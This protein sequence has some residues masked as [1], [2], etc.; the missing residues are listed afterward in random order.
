LEVLSFRLIVVTH[1]GTVIIL[2]AGQGTRMKSALPKVLHE[3]CGK[4]MIGWVIDQ[5]MSLD[6][7]KIVVV[8]GHGGEAVREVAMKSAG[9]DRIECVVQE[10]QNGTGHA[11]QVAAS[12]IDAGDGT[13]VV[14]YGDMPVLSP[15]SL[16]ELLEARAA[17]GEDGMA[18][19][20]ASPDDPTGLGRIERDEIGR[21]AGIVEHKDANEEQR[22]IGEVNLGVYA[23]HGAGLI[24]CL[25]KLSNDNAQKEYYLTDVP[26]MFVGNG[27]MVATVELDDAEEAIGVNN[28]MQLAE[29][30]W[31]LQVRILEEHLANGVRIEDPASTYVDAD[32][33][34]G[35]GTRILPCTV[36]RAGVVIGEDCEVGPFS[37]LR[38]GTELKDRAE[39]G[40][41][42]ES[43][44]SVLGSGT[45]AKHLSYLGDARIG[46]KVNVGAG[47]I[48]A[49]YDGV[50]KHITVVGDGAFI[51]SGTT[52]VGPNQIAA[53]ATTG[54]NS[55][56]TRSARIEENE[57]WAGIPARKFEGAKSAAQLK[58]EAAVERAN[59]KPSPSDS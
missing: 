22:D 24:E 9:A 46:E 27:H 43:K 28:L 29:A 12:A 52:I 2:A 14:L 26:A 8:I 36:I 47:T 50:N 37:H 13:V 21:F 19:L 41:F 6:P 53:R 45:K 48:F 4:P 57:V 35:K 32:V 49:N 38:K 56:V 7:K 1:T 31:A 10:P 23:F 25:P 33:V 59:G 17:A 51:G 16:Q 34:I 15:E 55:V 11:L 20:T 42:T 40:N 58:V 5:A 30:R 54:A 44:N 3:I 18:M 39:I